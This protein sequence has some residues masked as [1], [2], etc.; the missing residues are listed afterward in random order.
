VLDRFL[1]LLAT[2]EH[3][4]GRVPAYTASLAEIECACSVDSVLVISLF[5]Q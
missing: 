5:L 3:K 2:E 4:V 1:K